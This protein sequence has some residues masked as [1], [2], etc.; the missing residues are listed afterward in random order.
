[1]ATKEQNV[2]QEIT[3]TLLVKL[4]FEATV[5]VT[6]EVSGERHSLLASVSIS[7]GQNFLIGQYGLN[8]SAL[9][10]L[11]RILVR[12]SIGEKLEITVDINGY[13]AEKRRSVEKEAERAL[14][15]VLKSGASVTLRPM[16]SYE[17]KIVH[18]AIALHKEVTTESTGMNEKRRV[19]VLPKTIVTSL[20]E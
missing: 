10:H 7:T 15:E 5:S 2:V 3:E 8:L 17:R 9:Q 13:L 1:M 18:D 20:G 14:E 19:V 12:R 6:E 11:V 16:L 4:G